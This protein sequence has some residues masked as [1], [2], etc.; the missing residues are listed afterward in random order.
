[1]NIDGLTGAN[2]TFALEGFRPG[3]MRS[4]LGRWS[5]S[6]AALNMT[7]TEGLVA[8]PHDW[9]LYYLWKKAELFAGG[10]LAIFRTL[11][12]LTLDGIV[13]DSFRGD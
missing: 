5:I 7:S 9:V 11:P 1:M 12:H 10:Q 6:Y 3:F 2:S 8:Q 4:P 13:P